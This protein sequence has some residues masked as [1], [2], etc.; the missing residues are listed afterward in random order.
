MTAPPRLTL[1]ND[2]LEAEIAPERGARLCRLRTRRDGVDLLVPLST[3][4]A[5]EHGWPKAG[6]YPLVPYS[7]RI[8]DARV[9]FRGV[10]YALAPHPLDH[11]NA[12]HGHA[13]RRAWTV[14][15]ADSRCT[16]LVLES[17][18]CDDWPWP[19][20]ARIGFELAGHALAVSLCLHN[21]G[22]QAMPAGLGWHPFLA[23]DPRSIVHFGAARR[24]QID[25]DCLPT[26][27]TSA[28]AARH[29]LSPTDWAANDY[30]D[31][32]SEWNG[33]TR[34]ERDSGT[35][36]MA[37]DSPLTHLVAY[38]ARGGP[39]VCLEPV[40]HVANGFNLAAGGIDGT[41]MQVLEPGAS[42]TAR[43]T[44]AWTPNDQAAKCVHDS[45][46]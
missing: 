14:A 13:Q 43:V 41:G 12:L 22:T 45:R 21:P 26:G 30:V 29:A 19:F 1:S 27:Q 2:L 10:A 3:W 42:L 40:S 46:C 17:D 44:L 15:H 24:W 20:E 25:A 4:D 35:L 23:T 34:I 11:P 8:R 33:A 18:A 36:H 9:V 32:V 28:I 39:F 6:A 38:A 16:E 5:P 37:S 31:Y 7:N